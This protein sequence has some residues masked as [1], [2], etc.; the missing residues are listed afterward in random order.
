MNQYVN[1][2]F[3]A[4]YK[5]TIGADFLTKE[6]M[7]DD[8]L[9][10]LQVRGAREGER[11][12]EREGEREGERNGREN[13]TGGRENGSENRRENGRDKGGRTGGR[14]GGF[15]GA[16]ARTR[17]LSG[18][19]PLTQSC[20]PS[21]WPAWGQGASSLCG[22][23]ALFTST[24]SSRFDFHAASNSSS[25]QA[26]NSPT[27]FLGCVAQSEPRWMVVASKGPALSATLRTTLAAFWAS[28]KTQG[29]GARDGECQL[30]VETI[31]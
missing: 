23:R 12:G 31:L 21:W 17:A 8:K 28:P 13:G 6:V 30:E 26:R 25:T 4:Q 20:R 19:W 3:S 24:P 10:T 1:K 22:H 9:V 16:S 29:G 2:R 27:S 11:K 14:T 18:I 7:I 15:R 5:A